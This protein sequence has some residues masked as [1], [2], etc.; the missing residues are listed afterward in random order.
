MG[1]QHEELI[2]SR[3][4]MLGESD[5]EAYRMQEQMTQRAKQMQ[6][7][8]EDRDDESDRDSGKISSLFKGQTEHKARL[9]EAQKEANQDFKAQQRFQK[10]MLA[11]SNHRLQSQDGPDTKLTKSAA[12]SLFKGNGQDSNSAHKEHVA[13]DAEEAVELQKQFI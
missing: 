9:G 12:T 11:A 3:K 13:T 2:N 1:S 10:Q 7:Q 8:T 6:E 4:K 5:R